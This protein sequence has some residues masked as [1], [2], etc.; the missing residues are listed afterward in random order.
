MLFIRKAFGLLK[1]AKQKVAH[2][3]SESKKHVLYQIQLIHKPYKKYVFFSMV[4][5]TRCTFL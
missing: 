1:V 5:E 3:L 4:L 2:L